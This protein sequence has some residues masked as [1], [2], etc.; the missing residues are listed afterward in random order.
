MIPFDLDAALEKID[1]RPVVLSV[2]GGKDSTAT[3][4]VLREAGI[5]FRCVHMDTGWEHP[6]TERYVRDVLPGILGPIEIVESEGME[7]LVRRKGMFPSRVRRFCTQ[8]LKVKP[9]LRWVR[10]TEDETG[11]ELVNA[12]GIRAGESAARSK[13]E[14][15]EYNESM[16][17]DV[18]RPIISLSFDDV[19]EVHR[20]NGVVPNPLY[21]KGATRVGCWPCIFARKKEVR[22]IADL[23]PGRIDKIE[24]LEAAATAA[25]RARKAARGEPIPPPIAFFQARLPHHGDGPRWP[26]WPIRKVV[27]WSKTTRGGKQLGMFPDYESDGCMRWGMCEAPESK[28]TE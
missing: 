22:L 21:L 15:W 2:S 18:W 6:D 20:R 5:P 24:E 11:E 12:V 25:A 4:L 7:A 14:E 19:V 13:L 27:E 28:E 9:F 17:L 26:C 16:D 10:A 23:D 1:G 3:G 8:E